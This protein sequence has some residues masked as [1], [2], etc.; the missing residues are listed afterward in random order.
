MSR[1][2]SAIR[3]LQAQ[4]VCLELAATLIAA[5]PGCVLELGLG[6]GRSFDHLRALLP[7]RAIYC[8]DRRCAAHPDCI[9]GEE[10]LFLGELAATLPAAALRLAGTAVLVHSDIGSGD[11]A[12]SLAQA[13]W[14]AGALPPLLAPGAT[15]ASDQPL[16]NPA[17]Q[18]IP[19][20][21]GIAPDRY[22]IYRA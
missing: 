21:P 7:E 3:R 11:K 20:P 6:N 15:I 22:H 12:A 16:P 18:P 2:E 5:R 8:F 4:K 9:P 1:L 10:R 17:W 19:P 14:L 13:A